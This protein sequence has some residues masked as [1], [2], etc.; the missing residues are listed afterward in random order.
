MVSYCFHISVIPQ[1]CGS[2]IEA[3]IKIK[4]DMEVATAHR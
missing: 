3:T 4:D 1:E 2:G